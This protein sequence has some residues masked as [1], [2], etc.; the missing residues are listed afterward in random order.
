MRMGEI[1]TATWRVSVS[2]IWQTQ[3]F[4]EA[5]TFCLLG[6]SFYLK[7]DWYSEGGFLY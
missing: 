7:A 6:R 3:T 5:V 1:F 4:F 2:E